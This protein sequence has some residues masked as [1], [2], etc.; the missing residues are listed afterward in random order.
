MRGMLKWI[1]GLNLAVLTV[2]AFA[3]PHLMISPGKVID[4]HR[5]LT[6][7][8]FACHT[9]LLGPSSSRCI[10]CHT[11]KN[12]GIVTTKGVPITAKK[13]KVAFH[14]SLMDNACVDCHK[15]H[16]SFGVRHD[17]PYFSHGLLD[18]QTQNA[19]RSC[20]TQPTDKQHKG[21]TAECSQCHTVK[22][23]KPAAFDH[24]L[25]STDQ[26][27]NCASCHKSKTPKDDMHRNVSANCGACHTTEKWK[28]ATFDHSK[29]FI[30][31]SDH[32]RCATCHRQPSKDA[33]DYKQY[34]CY[35]CHEH[36]PENVRREHLEEG[37]RDF[38]DCVKCHRSADEDDAERAW[39]AIRRGLSPE[40]V[41]PQSQESFFDRNWRHDDDDD[42]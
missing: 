23:W 40:S 7:D 3:Y 26:R 22:G 17:N 29:Y 15:E 36:S 11:V 24:K 34:G 10:E 25:L 33:P 1:L 38:E 8:C 12:I 5:D 32:K 37:I 9:V 42:D 18:A 27:R 14:Q 19:C 13:T 6:E 41:R 35:F 28:P 4:Q 16:K 31:D 39:K 21:L 20:H 2:L 30:F